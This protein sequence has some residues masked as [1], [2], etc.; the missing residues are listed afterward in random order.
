VGQVQAA[1][2]CVS[3]KHDVVLNHH[4]TVG[5]E[6]EEAREK[7]HVEAQQPAK[8]SDVNQSHNDLDERQNSIEGENHNLEDDVDVDQTRLELSDSVNH[9]RNQCYITSR[10]D[11]RNG[12]KTNEESIAISV[13]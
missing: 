9:E 7:E 8:S 11:D 1:L 10:N 5:V 2:L 6:V 3:A 12:E 4:E 13:E